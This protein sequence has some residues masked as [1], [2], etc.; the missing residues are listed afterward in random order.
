[1]LL[2]WLALLLIRVAERRAGQTWPGWLALARELGRLHAV[3]LTGQTGTLA[4]NT[5]LSTAQRDILRPAGSP[6]PPGSPPY[7][8]PDLYEC[9]TGRRRDV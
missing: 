9:R 6:P 4:Q 1:V 2:C 5:E 3:T 8:R 7:T